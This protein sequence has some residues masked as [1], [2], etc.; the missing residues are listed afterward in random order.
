MSIESFLGGAGR[1]NAGAVPRMP[2]PTRCANALRRQVTP[3]YL[4][5]VTFFG[6]TGSF[7]VDLL[8]DL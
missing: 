2:H 5:M 8:Q 3:I 4:F 7:V 1:A 6:A